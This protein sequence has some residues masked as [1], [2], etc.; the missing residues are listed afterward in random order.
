MDYLITQTK[1]VIR[2]ILDDF[3]ILYRVPSINYGA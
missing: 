1:H 2:D 3:E